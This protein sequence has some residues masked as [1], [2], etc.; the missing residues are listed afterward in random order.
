MPVAIE[1]GQIDPDRYSPQLKQFERNVAY[2]EKHNKVKDVA[3]ATFASFGAIGGIVLFSLIDKPFG[4]AACIPILWVGAFKMVMAT[5]KYDLLDGVPSEIK[6]LK[7]LEDLFNFRFLAIEDSTNEQ[8]YRV[9]NF[10]KDFLLIANSIEKSKFQPFFGKNH[11]ALRLVEVR[12]SLI[13]GWNS[14]VGTKNPR[15]LD[16]LNLQI[17]KDGKAFLA[18]YFEHIYNDSKVPHV[19]YDH[20]PTCITVCKE[21]KSITKIQRIWE[22]LSKLTV[23]SVLAK[24]IV[25]AFS[26]RAVALVRGNLEFESM[27]ENIVLSAL[28][29]MCLTWLREWREPQ[30]NKVHKI[31]EVLSALPSD[32]AAIKTV[33]AASAALDQYKQHKDLFSSLEATFKPSVPYSLPTVLEEVESSKA[34]PEQF[35]VKVRNLIFCQPAYNTPLLKRLR[36]YAGLPAYPKGFRRQ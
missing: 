20:S 34:N 13:S 4:I 36:P 32:F 29:W 7:D 18:D 6:V 17:E 25:Q 22:T 19:E 35:I 8:L 33:E 27:V 15:E 9:Q 28:T 31:I 11:F 21:L 5:H 24:P 10:S 14:Y 12:N 2:V 23:V 26:A 30:L 1:G 3:R 16:A